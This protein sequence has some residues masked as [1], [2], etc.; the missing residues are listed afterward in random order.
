M[1]TKTSTNTVPFWI[2]GREASGSG[3]RIGEVT[4]SATGEVVKHVPFASP[5]DVD[6]A[7]KAA[8]EAWPEWRDTTPLR[9]ARVLMAVRDLVDNILV[10]LVSYFDYKSVFN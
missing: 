3:S 9:R 4:N 6:T 1:A 5:A 2:N 8:R 7:V 10:F